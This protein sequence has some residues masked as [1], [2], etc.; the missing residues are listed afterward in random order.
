[1]PEKLRTSADHLYNAKTM[2]EWANAETDRLYGERLPAG[3][4][5]A[6]LGLP[7]LLYR[8]VELNLKMAELT[9]GAD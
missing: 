3:H 5:P 7:T 9:K 4:S 1:M 2:L 6:D 8:A